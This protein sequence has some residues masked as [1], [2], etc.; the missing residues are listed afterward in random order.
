MADPVHFTSE[1]KT[2]KGMEAE[3]VFMGKIDAGW[4]V[5]STDLGQDGPIAATF[6]V[7]KMEGVETVGKLVARGHE[8]KKYDELFGMELKYFEGAV[9][10]VQKVRFTKPQYV[11]DCYLEYGT[12]DDK[13]CLPPTQVAFSANGEVKNEKSEAENDNEKKNNDVQATADADSIV[14]DTISHS[15]LL[16]SH[17]EAGTAEQGESI[18]AI[19]SARL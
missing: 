14:A 5:Y 19:S 1:L 10:F 18:R 2:G 4:H 7:V 3:I 17:F 16:I 11:I 6:N 13:S 12:C 15:S 8:I 9:T